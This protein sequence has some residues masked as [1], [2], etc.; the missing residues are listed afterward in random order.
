MIKK[1]F[2]TLLDL[3]FI[4]CLL[5]GRV[6]SSTQ[7]KR[8][9]ANDFGPSKPRRFSLEEGKSPFNVR[10]SIFSDPSEA[11]KKTEWSAIEKRQGAGWNSRRSSNSGIS[12]DSG[13]ERRK[14]G[15]D[16]LNKLESNFNCIKL[17]QPTILLP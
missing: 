6:K 8:D 14:K 9:Q 1:L 15:I 13:K 10:S 11:K 17:F 12:V 3:T 4:S 16:D 5:D 2:T 7:G